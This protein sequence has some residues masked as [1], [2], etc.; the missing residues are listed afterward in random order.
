MTSSGR[1]RGK[2]KLPTVQFQV[3]ILKKRLKTIEALEGDEIEILS[4]R[5]LK[6]GIKMENLKRWLEEVGKKDS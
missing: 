5:L 3:E 4:K 6:K 1:Q 2:G